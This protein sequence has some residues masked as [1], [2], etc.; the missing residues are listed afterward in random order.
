MRTGGTTMSIKTF[1]VFIFTVVSL[2]ACTG[3]HLREDASLS[4]TFQQI[5]L[6]GVLENNDFKNE[7]QMAIE[8][9]GGTLKN[10]ASTQ[11]KLSNIREG[12]QIVAYD[13]DR[14]ARVYLLSLKLNYDILVDAKQSVEKNVSSIKS[15]RLNLDKTFV[16]DADFALG[17]A[18]EEKQI[19]QKLYA[20]AS[21]L[22]LL[23][24]KYHN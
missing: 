14:K 9:A 11:L 8:E 6:V 1:L 5:E 19:R 16:Y 15:Q 18:E 17:K 10:G 20:E 13:S 12:K 24:L 2:Q 23:R 22:I 4:P 21:R 7:L 3:F